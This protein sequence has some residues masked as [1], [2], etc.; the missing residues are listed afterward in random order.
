MVNGAKVCA[1]K[2]ITCAASRQLS[3]AMFRPDR[4]ESL[5]PLRPPN[6]LFVVNHAAFFVSHRLPLAEAARAAGFVVQVATMVPVSERDI[7]AA[8]VLRE[9]GFPF[10]PVPLSRSGL[11]P[12][13]EV[14]TISALFALYRKLKP[15]LAR[16]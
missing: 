5:A 12:L 16:Q 8:A 10:H 14:R 11:N 1:D 7:N 13:Q 3:L 15:R 4:H 2:V 6:L 9:R